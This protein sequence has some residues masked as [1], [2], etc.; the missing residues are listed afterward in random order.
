MMITASHNPYNYN[1]IKLFEHGVDASEETTNHLEKLINE[2]GSLN[3]RDTKEVVKI[4]FLSPYFNFVKKFID[5]TPDAQNKILVDFIHGTGVKTIPYFKRYYNLVH[6]EF[7]RGEQ[8]ALTISCP[9]GPLE[10]AIG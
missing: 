3:K 4:D 7:L 5:I 6:L 8:R 9:K 2:P 1:G 10:E